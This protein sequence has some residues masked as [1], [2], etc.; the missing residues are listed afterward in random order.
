MSVTATE[1]PDPAARPINAAI[2]VHGLTKRFG[3]RAAVD[4]FD[5][6]VPEGSLAGNERRA[7]RRVRL[8]AR[9]AADS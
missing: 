2:V 4:N 1:R 3:Q 5:F 6:E 9:A 7:D 8:V